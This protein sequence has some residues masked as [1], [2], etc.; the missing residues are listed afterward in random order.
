MYKTPSSSYK[1]KTPEFVIDHLKAFT[2]KRYEFIRD[3]QVN[4]NNNKKRS[5]NETLLEILRF[6]KS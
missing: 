5:I 4:N 2:M 6:L 3:R 1:T